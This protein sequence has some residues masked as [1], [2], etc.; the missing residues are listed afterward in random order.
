MQRGGMIRHWPFASPYLRDFEVLEERRE[1]RRLFP[2]TDQLP[3]LSK[4]INREFEQGL[5]TRLANT[6]ERANTWRKLQL[7]EAVQGFCSIINAARPDHLH[8]CPYHTPTLLTRVAVVQHISETGPDG[9]AHRFRFFADDDFLPDV[10]LA[11]KPMAFASHAIDRYAERALRTAFHPLA[12]FLYHFFAT[13]KLPVLLN[14]NRPAVAFLNGGSMVAMPYKENSDE[15]FFLTT[16]GPEQINALSVPDPLP[17]MHLHYGPAYNPPVPGI[18]R[19]GLV[20]MVLQYWREKRPPNDDREHEQQLLEQMSF[21]G[22]VKQIDRVL[23]DEG[24]AR[25]RA[26]SFRTTSMVHRP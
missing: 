11:G 20:E 23:R 21:T 25:T 1:G 6:D 2:R 19:S 7:S 26:F 14:G 12:V 15:Y 24:H 5:T 22:L 13:A 9:L 3:V 8:V 16:L 18:D 10:F 17:P 4:A